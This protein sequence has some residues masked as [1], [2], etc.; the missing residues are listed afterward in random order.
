MDHSMDEQIIKI[1]S[2]VFKR[3]INT[4]NREVSLKKDLRMKSMQ[5]F[6]VIARLESEYGLTAAFGAVSKA[7]TIGD[8]ID[9]VYKK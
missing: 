4:L 2:I 6:A 8:F 3:D 9:L 5:T 1:F 7:E